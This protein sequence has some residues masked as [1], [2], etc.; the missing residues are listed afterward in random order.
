MSDSV[1]PLETINIFQEI[2]EKLEE[3]KKVK[4]WENVAR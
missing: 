1:R 3:K 2:K 4:S